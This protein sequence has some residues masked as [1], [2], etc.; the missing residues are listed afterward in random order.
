MTDKTHRT[1]FE[2]EAQEKS[3]PNHSQAPHL[4]DFT[5]LAIALSFQPTD[6]ENTS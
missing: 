4:L 6:D 3:N 2:T 5:I 1:R